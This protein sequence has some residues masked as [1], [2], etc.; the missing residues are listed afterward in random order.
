MSNIEI[1]DELRAFG[2]RH[3]FLAGAKPEPHI[4]RTFE[5]AR[6]SVTVRITAGEVKK[7]ALFSDTSTRVLEIV[8]GDGT[9]FIRSGSLGG[10]MGS[11]GADVLRRAETV[12]DQ[13]NTVSELRK[14]S[15]EGQ[16]RE[17]LD[18]LGWWAIQVARRDL[19]LPKSNAVNGSHDEVVNRI[20]NPPRA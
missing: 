6:T 19:G 1:D 18:T 20:L 14:L 16:I 12:L 11:P 5:L 4:H 7:S 15:K 8:G 17:A 2:K 13:L 10:S 9:H 3:G